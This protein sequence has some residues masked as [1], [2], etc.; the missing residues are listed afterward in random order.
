MLKIVYIN[1]ASIGKMEKNMNM[2]CAWH[3]KC[4]LTGR[5]YFIV[6]VLKGYIAG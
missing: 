2:K 4:S 5:C 6:N 1:Y 3:S